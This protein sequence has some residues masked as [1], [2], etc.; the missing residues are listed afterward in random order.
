MICKQIDRMLKSVFGCLLFFTTNNNGNDRQ[1][2]IF[3]S[4]VFCHLCV[5]K[6]RKK[7]KRRRENIRKQPQGN[8]K[9]NKW[10]Y[11]LRTE[12]WDETGEKKNYVQSTTLLL[13]FF[14]SLPRSNGRPSSL[15]FPLFLA[16]ACPFYPLF[17]LSQT[18]QILVILESAIGE[19][20]SMKGIAKAL[21]WNVLCQCTFFVMRLVL[22]SVQLAWRC[23][24]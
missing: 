4:R 16:L 15:S 2:I 11:A 6:R 1:F 3:W 8:L 20:H 5:W 10:I 19:K 22:H 13:S 7:Y 14:L 23:K 9:Q 21:K 17:A 12:Q 24:A 18:E